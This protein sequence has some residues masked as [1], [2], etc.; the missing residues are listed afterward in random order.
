MKKHASAC[1]YVLGIAGSSLGGSNLPKNVPVASLSEWSMVLQESSC[2]VDSFGFYKKII[3][4]A[5]PKN[6]AA[7]LCPFSLFFIL[8][9]YLFFFF[10]VFS[11]LSF[12]LVFYILSFFLPFLFFSFSHSPA[13]VIIN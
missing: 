9:V 4:S 5:G 10:L 6:T 2:G 3:A 13:T 7:F 8:S 12:F 1:F 11:F